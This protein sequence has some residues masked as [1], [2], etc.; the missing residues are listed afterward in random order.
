MSKSPARSEA[1]GHM[2][3]A[4]QKIQWDCNCMFMYFLPSPVLMHAVTPCCVVLVVV[5][6]S[7]PSGEIRR[8]GSGSQTSRYT[9][10]ILTSI[11]HCSIETCTNWDAI[12]SRKNSNKPSKWNHDESWWIMRCPVPWGWKSETPQMPE[13]RQVQMSLLQ[14]LL[15][16]LQPCSSFDHIT[17]NHNITMP[18]L[19]IF[20]QRLVA[21]GGD[22]ICPCLRL[23]SANDV[24]LKSDCD[25]PRRVML[26]LRLES[27][28]FPCMNIEK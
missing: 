6:G 11:V 19:C 4:M 18:S 21:S 14:L 8:A 12:F 1:E 13:R 24:A 27:S 3:Y 5:P 22:G 23:K 20:C 28:W 9:A 2:T 10:G 15:P 25:R 16:C 17:S 7:T 26:L